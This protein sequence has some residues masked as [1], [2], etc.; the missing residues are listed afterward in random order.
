MNA[1]QASNNVLR[2]AAHQWCI[3]RDTLKDFASV[4]SGSLRSALLKRSCQGEN[5]YDFSQPQNQR[6]YLLI[7][8]RQ[9]R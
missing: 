8:D 7:N 1:V 3:V 4:A 2:V 5:P 6:N 9:W